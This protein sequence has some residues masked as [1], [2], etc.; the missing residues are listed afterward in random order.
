M[1]LIL[2]NI[3]NGRKVRVK[4]RENKLVYE[5]VG[6][7]DDVCGIIPELCVGDWREG[8]EA[9]LI[10]AT[11]KKSILEGQQKLISHACALI[12]LESS[13]LALRKDSFLDQ[14]VFVGSKVS[15][16]GNEESCFI[17]EVL[18]APAQIN[19][20]FGEKL[21]FAMMME[22][23]LRKDY[24]PLVKFSDEEARIKFSEMS[25]LVHCIWQD[26]RRSSEAKITGWIMQK[27]IP[28][29]VVAPADERAVIQKIKKENKAK[30]KIIKVF[31]GPEDEKGWILAR[32]EEG[33]E[34]PLETSDLCFSFLSYGLKQLEGRWLEL[35]VKHFTM[36]GRPILSNISRIITELQSIKQKVDQEGVV[37]LEAI[38]DRIDITGR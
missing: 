11:K 19:V 27:G 22:D 3:F 17:K 24:Q 29:A 37:E 26:E 9:F 2:A 7:E 38:I 36:S 34:L 8:D 18:Y 6:I 21:D 20:N 28:C 31:K 1:R 33:I 30:V 14:K 4:T 25:E 12:K 15:V 5:L 10:T 23:Y 13:S 16:V 32:T 35:P